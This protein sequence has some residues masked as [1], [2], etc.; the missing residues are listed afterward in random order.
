MVQHI[1]MNN[2]NKLKLIFFLLDFQIEIKTVI[3]INYDFYK[4]SENVLL[5]KI[6]VIFYKN[7]N[8]HCM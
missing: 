7:D 5:R 2:F 4:V 1:K 8:F 6:I 3:S